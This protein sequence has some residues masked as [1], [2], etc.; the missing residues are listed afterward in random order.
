MKEFDNIYST[1]YP[2]VYSYILKLCQN[3]E[4][5]EEVTQE[6]FF[7]AFKKINTYRGECKLS[8]WICQIAKNE[9]FSQLKHERRF[10]DL[11]PELLSTEN[12]FEQMLENKDMA[13]KI[14]QILHTL[15]EPYR[16]VFWMR[17][18]GELSFKEIGKVHEK[19]ENWAR[20]TYH[21]AKM[22]IKERIL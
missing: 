13:I 21:R 19:T 3:E 10:T 4:L 11:P 14:H 6:A 17:T 9:L 16:E 7:K 20:V 1:Y 8:V 22:R 2:K 18:F 15:E 12:D 5:A